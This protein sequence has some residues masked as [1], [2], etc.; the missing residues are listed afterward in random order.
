M[1]NKTLT[2]VGI[3]MSLLLAN[4]SQAQLFKRLKD[5]VTSKIGDKADGMIDDV[6][7]K[8][9]KDT[10][11]RTSTS[12]VNTAFF[13]DAAK[14]YNFVPGNTVIFQD[15][16]SRDSLGTMAQHWKTSGSGDIETFRLRN[17]R[18]LSLN[19]FTSYKLKRDNPLPENFTIEFDIATQSNTNAGDLETLSF[20]FA[21]DNNISDYISD[22]YNDNAITE[23]QIHY[24]NKEVNN[25]SSDTKINNTIKFPLAAYAVGIMHVAIKVN[26]ENMQ[27]FLDKAK[28][29]DTHM[30][31]GTS[32]TKY[33][34]IS[35]G[36]RLDNGA[37][38]GISNFTI[39]A[40]ENGNV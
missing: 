34:Y 40:I 31:L 27:V 37:K 12:S 38:I 16:F 18:W 4:H 17:G 30:F 26:G 8:K 3:A 21:H 20:G 28:V 10:T 13:M 23:T 1:K 6:F 14:S 5:K 36:T 32:K 19:E 22:A 24:W 39:A 2:L 7:S 15:N 11:L 35:T 33:F 9:S 25:S 29:L